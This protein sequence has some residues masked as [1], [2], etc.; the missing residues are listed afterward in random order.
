[1]DLKGKLIRL[2]TYI[3]I[4][5]SPHK[6][7]KMSRAFKA[8]K[9]L[10]EQVSELSSKR[11][12]HM[13]NET[14]DDIIKFIKE[15][16]VMFASKATGIDYFKSFD[17]EFV[18]MINYLL[19]FGLFIYRDNEFQKN[20]VDFIFSYLCYIL[21]IFTNKN[22]IKSVNLMDK[23]ISKDTILSGS[24][25]LDPI[26]RAAYDVKYHLLDKSTLNLEV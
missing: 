7:L 12:A 22:S 26:Q 5:D 8:F 21:D 20:D 24:S 15:Y 2:L 10:N 18:R 23:I 4:D 13:S 25:K 1:M 6:L 14:L 19:R 11:S 3:Y 17:M 9:S 16:T